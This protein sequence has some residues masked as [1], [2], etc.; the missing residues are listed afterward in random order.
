MAQRK[1]KRG[2]VSVLIDKFMRDTLDPNRQTLAFSIGNPIKEQAKPTGSS[3]NEI[4]MRSDYLY[5]TVFPGHVLCG[6][7]C[8]GHTL[9]KVPALVLEK[10]T[11]NHDLP[12]FNL[13]KAVCKWFQDIDTDLN[14]TIEKSE[15][16]SEFLQMGLPEVNADFFLEQF[17]KNT[18][19]VLEIEEFQRAI[20]HMLDT[21]IPGLRSLDIIALF[22]CFVQQAAHSQV[23]LSDLKIDPMQFLTI[24]KDLSASAFDF[25][26]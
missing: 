24:T 9:P 13:R 17:D 16:L 2:L 21:S 23:S 7:H 4:G 1:K 26:G 18:N 12:S 25:T 3:E 11:K 20:V 19:G 15:L 5:T 8:E 14:N 10:L 22:A 6:E